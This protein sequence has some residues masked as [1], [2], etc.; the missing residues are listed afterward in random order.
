MGL[1][2]LAAHP[3]LAR[4]PGEVWPDGPPATGAATHA[5]GAR[6][7]AS[8]ATGSAAGEVMSPPREVYDDLSPEARAARLRSLPPLLR[9]E[10]SA[11]APVYV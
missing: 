4:H 7:G 8:A 10:A 5:R 9:R 6:P 3:D 1:S 11:A 2:V